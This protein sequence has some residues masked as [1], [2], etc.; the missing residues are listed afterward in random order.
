[1]GAAKSDT[2]TVSNNIKQ[3]KLAKLI[4]SVGKCFHVEKEE[5]NGYYLKIY[6]YISIPAN[7][8]PVTELLRLQDDSRFTEAF[9]IWFFDIPNFAK[10]Y[11]KAIDNPNI[12]DAKFNEMDKHMICQYSQL[13]KDE[14]TFE[15]NN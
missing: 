4:D 8:R 3:T 7:V 1:M 5:G 10:K 11:I 14:G 6:V 12:S 15:F 9:D 13:R 2:A